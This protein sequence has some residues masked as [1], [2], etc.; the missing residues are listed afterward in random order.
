V[1]K[2]SKYEFDENGTVISVSEDAEVEEVEY[3]F[4]EDGTV[5]G[6]KGETTKEEKVEENPTTVKEE[7]EVPAI[8]EPV[9][10]E[11]APVS[12]VKNKKE[13]STFFTIFACIMTGVIVYLATLIGND[14]AKVVDPETPSKDSNITSNV[15]SNTT[16]NVVSNTNGTS[17]ITSNVVSNTTTTP[18]ATSNTVS[19][20][21]APVATSNTTAP[22][23][24]SNAVAR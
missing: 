9:K 23:A 24:T 5:I 13:S 14:A 17:N 6:I 2:K 16:S 1:G 19:N 20:T 10:E 7:V 3:E 18:A 12:A 8:E 21:T 11:T 15:V 22:V 4:D